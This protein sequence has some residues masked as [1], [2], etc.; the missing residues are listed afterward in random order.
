[1]VAIIGTMVAVIGVSMSRDTDRLARLESERF[2]LMVAEMRDEAILAGQNYSLVVEEKTG[3]WQ[4]EE[5]HQ[6]SDSG[7]DPSSIDARWFAPRKVQ[8]GV[9]LEWEITE[10]LQNQRTED[11]DQEPA[12]ADENKAP[13]VWMTPLG[14]ITPFTASFSG[15]DDRWEV[16]VNEENQLQRRQAL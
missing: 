14:E 4:F 1:M 12:V 3:Y 9:E 7:S 16:Y 2:L 5:A 13:K 8:Q 6:N 11:Q 10:I 15:E